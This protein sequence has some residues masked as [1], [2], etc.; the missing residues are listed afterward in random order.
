MTASRNTYH[1]ILFRRHDANPVLSAIDWPYAAN[2]VFNPGAVRM[3]DGSTLLL[4]RVEDRRGH[5]HPPGREQGRRSRP[6]GTR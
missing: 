3:D 4:C 2:S 1:E 5:S 6:S